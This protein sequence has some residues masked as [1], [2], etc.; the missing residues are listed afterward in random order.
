MA[1]LDADVCLAVEAG[2]FGEVAAVALLDT[3]V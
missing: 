1:L 3:D 2:L